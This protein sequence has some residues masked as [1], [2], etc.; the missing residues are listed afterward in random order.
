MEEMEPSNH[1]LSRPVTSMLGWEGHGLHVRVCPSCWSERGEMVPILL[2]MVGTFAMVLPDDT[3]VG[4]M[5]G[6]YRF[7]VRCSWSQ[8]NGHVSTTP[9]GD[10]EWG[11]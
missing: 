11:E 8:M 7:C 6:S 3:E 9:A 5:A 2:E 4:R 1:E 10:R